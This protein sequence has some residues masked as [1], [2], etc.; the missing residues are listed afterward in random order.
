MLLF[1]NLRLREFLTRIYLVQRQI[2]KVNN[3]CYLINGF[4]C[5]RSKQNLGKRELEWQVFSKLFVLFRTSRSKFF[6]EWLKKEHCLEVVLRR[7][8]V[9]KVFFKI[10]QNSQEYTCTRVN[11]ISSNLGGLFRSPFWGGAGVKITPPLPHTHT[12]TYTLLSK[13]RYSDAR[14]LKLGT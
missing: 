8:S 12:H 14:K 10:Y 1:F 5:I 4:R 13:T 9:K 7:C 3:F 2:L 6:K 11:F